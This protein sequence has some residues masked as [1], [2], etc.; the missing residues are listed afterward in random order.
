MGSNH[1]LL[2]ARNLRNGAFFF[3]NGEEVPFAFAKVTIRM[4][5]R[6]PYAQAHDSTMSKGKNR[7]FQPQKPWLMDGRDRSS[8]QARPPPD[9][10]RVSLCNVRCQCVAAAATVAVYIQG[11]VQS[12]RN[13][14]YAGCPHTPLTGHLHA[15]EHQHTHSAHTPSDGGGER[16]S[17]PFIH[18][19]LYC[20]SRP[21]S[22]Y[23]CQRRRPLYKTFFSTDAPV[24]T[25]I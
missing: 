1:D 23:M 3:S 13:A 20:K 10:V 24:Q 8:N 15:N 7:Q 16:T 11:S 17:S 9:I 12:V 21:S 4:G 19:Y 6:W 2:L 22:S 18:D 14:R 5:S 25:I